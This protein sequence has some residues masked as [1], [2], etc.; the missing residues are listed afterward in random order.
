MF[1]VTSTI[2]QSA[3]PITASMPALLLKLFPKIGSARFA[4]LAKKTSLRKRN[5]HHIRNKT[6][7]AVWRFRFC[8]F[9]AMYLSF[10]NFKGD[11]VDYF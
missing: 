6:G 5:A 3:I 1:V 7:R 4:A 2:R 10:I 8:L 9:L 11:V